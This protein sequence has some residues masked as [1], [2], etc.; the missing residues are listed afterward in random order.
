MYLAKIKDSF[1]FGGSKYS[2]HWWLINKD[3]VKGV[4]AL[5]TTHLYIPDE[6]RMRQV[7][8]GILKKVKFTCFDTPSG[9]SKKKYFKSF[10]GVKLNY[11]NIKKNSVDIKKNF[12]IKK[13]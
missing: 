8:Y 5:E 11:R 4:Y 7:R 10:N 13:P 9:M 2:S 6:K 12:S 3:Q 1:M